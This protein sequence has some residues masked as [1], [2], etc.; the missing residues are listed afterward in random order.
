MKN[1]STPRIIGL[2][3]CGLILAGC[4]TQPDV[5]R[6]GQVAK[7]RPEQIDHYTQLHKNIWPEVAR[8][9]EEHNIRNYSIFIKELEPG[10]PYLFSYYEYWGNDYERDMAKMND[11]PV[12]QKWEVA[13][14]DE[15]LVKI[16]PSDGYWW[17]D[18]EEVFYFAGDTGVNVP[19]D[20]VQRYGM[21]IGVKP[22]MVDAYKYIHKHAWPEVLDAIERGHIRNYPIYMTEIEEKVYIFGYFEYVGDDFAGDMAAIDNNPATLAWIKFTDAACQVPIPTRKEGEWWADMKQ[23]FYHP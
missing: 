6:F 13:A 22:D 12:V 21:V 17:V 14:G 16:R 3:L 11:D 2:F 5:R 9:L 15:C 18:M 4:S 7:I 23:I 8:G 1:Q 19:A 10:E 20:K